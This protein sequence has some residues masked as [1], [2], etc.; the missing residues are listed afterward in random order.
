MRT[1]R[2]WL[3]ALSV[4]LLGSWRLANPAAI[5]AG[6]AEAMASCDEPI[7]H[8]GPCDFMELLCTIACPTWT[9]A[10]CYPNSVLWCLTG[11]S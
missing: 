6:D 3:Q 5:S 2:L 8:T 4:I 1:R 11:D 9:A 7:P 10:V